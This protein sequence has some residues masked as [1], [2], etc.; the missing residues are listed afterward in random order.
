MAQFKQ[1]EEARKI[2][3][4][5]GTATLKEIKNNYKKLALKYHPDRCKEDKKKEC[6][7]MFKKIAHANDLLTAYC[8]GYRYSFKEKDVKKNTM[9]KEFYQHLKKFYDGWWADLDL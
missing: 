6:E 9:G 3:G 8:A 1:I 2:L 5:E 4:L 7:E